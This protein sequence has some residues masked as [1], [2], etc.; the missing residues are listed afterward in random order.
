MIYNHGLERPPRQEISPGMEEPSVLDYL[1]S[2]LMPWKYPRVELP[3]EPPPT[4][5]AQGVDSAPAASGAAEPAIAQAGQPG[6]APGPTPVAPEQPPASQPPP[7]R[8]PWAGLLA[9]GLALAAQF[10]LGP[11]PQRGWLTGVLLFIGAL[12]VL[13]WTAWKEDLQTAPLPLPRLPDSPPTLRLSSLLTGLI[14]AVAA[15]LSFYSLE[16]G[17]LNTALLLAALF[18]V[19]RAFWKPSGWLSGWVARGRAFLADPR[20][21]LRFST[22]TLAWLAGIALVAF[23]RFYRLG[24]VPPEMNSDH[25]EKL[26][27]ILRVLNGQT[28]IFFPSNGGREALIFYL[29][30]ALHR[31]TGFPLGF[32]SLKVVSVSIGLGALPFLYGAGLELGSRRVGLLA[33]ILAGIAY[34]PNVV[35]RFGLRLPFAFLFTAALLYFL[36]RGL[37]SGTINPFVLAGITLGVSLYG[38]TPA[39]LLPLLV[40]AAIGL[41]LLHLRTRAHWQLGLTGLLAIIVLSLVLFLPML[42]FLLAEPDAFLL[43]TLSRMGTLER[44]LE[45]PAWLIFLNNTGRALAM[46]SW[47]AGE[48]WPISVP[49]YP[50]LGVA[51]GALFY[52]GA[53]LALVRYV[54]HRH[55]LDLCLILS[56]PI[57]QLPST[58]AL[59]FP[60]ENPNL[61]RTGGA[62]IPVFLLA[63]RALDGLMTSLE[64]WRPA[65]AGRLAAAALA[66]GLVMIAALQDYTLVFDAYYQ[67]YR[68]ASWNTSEIGALA[69][70]FAETIGSPDTIWVMGFPHWIDSRL[71]ATNAG[72]PG[73]DYRMFP[74]QLTNTLADPRPKLFI[75]NPQ[76]TQ[77]MQALR[78]LY[79][80]G[81][82]QTIQSKTPGKDFVLFFVPPA[83]QP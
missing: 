50:A 31:F 46:F 62:M 21:T 34:W 44:P 66:V 41:Y 12:A 51:V 32:M 75:L 24:E 61:Y 5:Y 2:R 17:V 9:L 47:D 30:A 36:L 48:I 26:L 15:F 10:S 23:F 70:E 59:A 64:A 37:R 39:R 6:S 7:G 76:D 40:L 73:R 78:Q 77:G 22:W 52:L 63:A 83:D 54:K 72:Y 16:F 43:R 79:H 14:L 29:G 74:E 58:L 35:S 42:R 71:V 28:L 8:F 45:D 4:G 11:A 18:Y 68:N 20:L 82:P 69:G 49:G 27:D 56:I 25:A 1:K 33:V 53:G 67:Q 3:P 80:Q 57:L 81:W 60:A 19:A 65:R 13:A 55:W 38:Y